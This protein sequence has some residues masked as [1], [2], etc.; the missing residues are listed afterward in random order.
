MVSVELEAP[1]FLFGGEER[2]KKTKSVEEVVP[3]GFHGATRVR[4]AFRREGAWGRD[5]YV[6]SERRAESGDL[7]SGERKWCKNRKDSILNLELP[8]NT[9]RIFLEYSRFFQK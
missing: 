6:S 4:H 2:V 7:E 3:P 8:L 9:I 1:H 5:L